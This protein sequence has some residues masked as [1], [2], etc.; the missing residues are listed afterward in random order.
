MKTIRVFS[1]LV[2]GFATT[3]LTRADVFVLD[4]LTESPFV[5]RGGVPIA[6]GAG[7]GVSNVTITNGGEIV[8]FDLFDGDMVNRHVTCYSSVREFVGSGGWCHQ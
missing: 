3:V 5:T 8:S 7:G 1:I 6:N 2:V 4:D